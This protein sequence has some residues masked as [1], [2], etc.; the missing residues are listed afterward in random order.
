VN[1]LSDSKFFI[2]I[3]FFILAFSFNIL[4]SGDIESFEVTGLSVLTQDVALNRQDAVNDALKKGMSLLIDKLKLDKEIAAKILADPSK[5]ISGYEVVEEKQVGNILN[6]T[7][8]I[9]ISVSKII[10]DFKIDYSS[11]KYYVT[12]SCFKHD[13]ITGISEV[14]HICERSIYDELKGINDIV[15][16]ISNGS[17]ESKRFD[18]SLKLKFI[19]Q[20]IKVNEVY[21]I[22]KKIEDLSFDIN[23]YSED[24][25]LLKTFKESAKIFSNLTDNNSTFNFNVNFF[26][27]LKEFLKNESSKSVGNNYSKRV[28]QIPLIIYNSQNYEDISHIFYILEKSNISFSIY[29]INKSGF[30]LIVKNYTV[31]D[32][33]KIIKSSNIKYKDIELKDGVRVIL[34]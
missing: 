10:D 3:L 8:K 29:R 5:Y 34:N 31:D 32:L 13:N 33:V 20:K 16:N 6:E 19:Y 11:K 17:N 21:S 24:N 2:L 7:L 27:E 22:G 9:D 26:A 18:Q 14:D 25:N 1:F 12:I 23:V 4:A 30:H 28:T 15:V